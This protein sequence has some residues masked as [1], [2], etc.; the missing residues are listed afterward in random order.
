MSAADWAFTLISLRFGAVEGNPVL[1][2]LLGT[3]PFL[4][5]SFKGAATLF[6]VW[7]MWRNR[8]YRQ[9]VAVSVAGFLLYF[10]LMAYHLGLL[11]GMG[12]I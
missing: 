10:A 12:A 8:A 4:A 7:L 11:A 3:D 9:V 6:V 2:S 1:A 5:A